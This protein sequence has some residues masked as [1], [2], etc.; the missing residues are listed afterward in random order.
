MPTS[1][2]LTAEEIDCDAMPL[3]AT[4]TRLKAELWC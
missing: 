2:T 3:T 4:P 1:V